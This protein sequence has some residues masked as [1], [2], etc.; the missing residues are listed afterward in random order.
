MKR[1][2]LL[3][4]ASAFMTACNVEESR[5]ELPVIEVSDAEMIVDAGSHSGVEL[6][7]ALRASG[8]FEAWAS[9]ATVVPTADAEWIKNLECREAG[10]VTFDVEANPHT[11]ERVASILLSLGLA[12]CEDV[13]VKVI[14]SAAD[15]DAGGG[16]GDGGGEGD[17]GGGET[18]TNVYRTGWAELPVER[19]TKYDAATL[20]YAHHLCA[21]GEKNAQNN[22]KARNYTVC[23]S[24]AHH[25][26]VWVAAPRHKM[27]EGSTKR[28]DAYA[29]DPEI[30]SGIQYLQESAGNSTYNRGHMLGS[31]ERTVSAATNRQV[32]Y[33]TNIA[34]QKNDTFNTGGG[35]WNK[36]EDWVDGKICSDTTYIVIGTYFDSYTDGYGYSASP[37]KIT[38]GGRSDVSCPT[39]F[40]Y[41]LL[42]TKS[43]KTGK[44]VTECRR[45]ELMC[46]AFVRSHECAKGTEVSRK[47]MISVAALEEITGFTYFANVPEAPKD[48]FNPSDWGL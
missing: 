9:E 1:F 11:V 29:P 28:T 27:Y 17:K 22:G 6:R 23:F 14:Q 2:L 3:V 19:S 31:A 15:E 40:Y 18:V 16:G 12:G 33:Y 21:G 43:G 5:P 47:D 46:A 13:E 30:P 34:P 7:Y 41:I 26:P 20:Y 32:F 42:R 48:S 10:L 24:S 38:Y 39:M 35:A 4:V 45:D 36:L 37:K 44:S 8:D 25:C